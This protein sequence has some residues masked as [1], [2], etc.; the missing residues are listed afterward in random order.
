[1]EQMPK[2][3]RCY[4]SGTG[5]N[6]KATILGGF[7]LLFFAPFSFLGTCIETHADLFSFE[8]FDSRD[9][10]GA[11]SLVTGY[12]TLE[13]GRQ[14][15]FTQVTSAVLSE[16]E[17]EDKDIIRADQ[18]LVYISINNFNDGLSSSSSNSEKMTEMNNNI[19]EAKDKSV[20]TMG[21]FHG[22][23]VSVSPRL[24][25]RHQVRRDRG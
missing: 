2:F 18:S 5:R 19:T 9:Y 23:N 24:R 6:N 1:M 7:R 16:D 11:F 3:K 22:L 14:Q 13:K 10:S 12:T 17:I 15:H 4:S 21:F 8:S 20:Y 25:E